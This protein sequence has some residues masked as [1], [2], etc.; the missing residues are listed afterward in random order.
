MLDARRRG[1]LVQGARAHA[2]RTDAARRRLTPRR[3]RRRAAW[4]RRWRARA[5]RAASLPFVWTWAWPLQLLA[6]VA[7][8]AWRGGRTPRRAA[9]ARLRRSARPGWLPGTW[10]MFIS[11]HHYGGLPAPLAAAAVALLCAG[12]VA[13]PGG[14]RWRCSRAGGAARPLADALLFARAVAARRTGA[15]RALHRLSVAGQRLCAGRSP[16]AALAPWIGVYGIGFVAGL[17]WPALRGAAALAAPA[18]AAAAGGAGGARPG[19]PWPAAGDFSRP[20][21]P[22]ERHAAADQRAAGREVRGRPHCR[23]ALD[24]TGVPLAAARGELVVAPET[25]VPL[26]PRASSRPEY[27][28]AHG[29]LRRAAGGR[30]GRPA[31]GRLRGGLHQLRGRAVGASGAAPAA[32]TA[33]TSATWC[34]SASSSRRAS[35]GSSR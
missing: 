21:R 29:A 18:C 19:R 2:S 35:A 12:A 6:C 26:L 9:L 1:A 14:W 11:L 13:V 20:T 8:L 5:R 32:S 3:A 17:R 7:A 10:W 15:R 33:T 34:R 16:L 28:R 24:W 31:A 25:A 4:A 30:A 27:W 23:Q 22:A